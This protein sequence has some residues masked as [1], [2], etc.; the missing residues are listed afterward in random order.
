M[1]EMG[2]VMKCA[3]VEEWINAKI[4]LFQSLPDDGQQ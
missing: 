2:K 1:A 3:N 4:E